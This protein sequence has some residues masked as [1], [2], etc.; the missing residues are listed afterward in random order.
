MTR[1]ESLFGKTI[2]DFCNKIGTQETV[3]AAARES[4]YRGAADDIRSRRVRLSMTHGGMIRAGL[5]SCGWSFAGPF[6]ARSFTAA[7]F[8]FL[9]QTRCEA[10]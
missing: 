3:S 5:A 9:S 1:T 4:A 7:A 2:N 10:G 8:A 6:M